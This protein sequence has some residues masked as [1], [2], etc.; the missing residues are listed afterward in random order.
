[1]QETEVMDL[2]KDMCSS[3]SELDNPEVK[4]Q[5]SSQIK[6]FIE[7]IF[8]VTQNSNLKEQMYSYYSSKT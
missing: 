8:D 7:S 2:L 1:M 3:L 5:Q 4:Q 6:D